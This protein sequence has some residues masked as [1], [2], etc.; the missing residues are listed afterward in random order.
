MG[1]S[2]RVGRSKGGEGEGRSVRVGRERG[3][4]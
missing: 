4:V 1:R 3:G 2:V